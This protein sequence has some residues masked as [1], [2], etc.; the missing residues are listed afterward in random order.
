MQAPATFTRGSVRNATWTELRVVAVSCGVV[1]ALSVFLAQPLNALLLGE[2][3]AG[4]LGIDVR[5]V[6]FLS[7]AGVAVLSGVITAFCG[8]IGFV[9]LAAPGA[10]AEAHR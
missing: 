7:L 9:G 4:S 5:R 3:C 6:H 8:A 10:R 2:R 1:P